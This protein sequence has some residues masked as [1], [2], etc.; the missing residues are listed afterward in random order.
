MSKQFPW[1]RTLRTYFVYDTKKRRVV[2]TKRYKK[3]ATPLLRGKLE[4]VIV[5]MT[6]T[7]IVPRIK[8]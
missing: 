7:Y 4:R 1:C 6:G 8:P 2:A 3:D 5:E